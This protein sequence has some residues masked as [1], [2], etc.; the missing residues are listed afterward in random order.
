MDLPRAPYTVL[1]N[2]SSAYF[3]EEDLP[4]H[5]SS[6]GLI[7]HRKTVQTTPYPFPDEHANAISS[8]AQIGIPSKFRK[9]D[10]H[11]KLYF[12]SLFPADLDSNN[13]A[14]CST[15]AFITSA[16]TPENAYL[17][18]QKHRLYINRCKFLE[19]VG[20]ILL[21][22]LFWIRIEPSWFKSDVGKRFLYLG[23]SGQPGPAVW[24]KKNCPVLTR[25]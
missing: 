3:C 11:Y 8:G 1:Q 23:R 17:T 2:W 15:V 24:R 18:I 10:L 14:G 9:L 7:Y 13:D 16:K 22:W 19:H 6:R 21:D 5:S 4:L 25:T 20:G 12:S